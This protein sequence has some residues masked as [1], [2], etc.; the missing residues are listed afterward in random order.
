MII[1]SHPHV[2]EEIEQYKGKL[3]F[4]S[5][6]NFVFDQYFFKETQEGLAV[7]LE[8]ANSKMLIRLFPLGINKG[9]PYLFDNAERIKFLENLSLKSPT[10]SKNQI[11]NG[12]ITIGPSNFFVAAAPAKRA[13][14]RAGKKEGGLGEG[15]FARLLPKRN[16]AAPPENLQGETE[17][18]NFLFLSE[19][20][21]RR[22]QNQKMRRKFFCEVAA[23]ALAE[24]DGGAERQNSQ[25]GF[26]S[27]K[28]RISSNKHH[29]FTFI[30]PRY[31]L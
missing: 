9:Q 25:S 29:C 2:V 20:K 7:G 24:A 5:L 22:A 8:F 28:V 10:V 12:I 16:P 31:Q 27:K 17:Q 4:Y 26:S 19:E 1:G 13:I 23:V 21:N 14:Q 6:G 18:K 3:I 30:F 11:I 15:I